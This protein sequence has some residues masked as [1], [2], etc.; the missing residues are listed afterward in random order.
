MTHSLQALAFCHAHSVYH[1]DVKPENIVWEWDEENHRPH[2]YLT[3][4]NGSYMNELDYLGV[5]MFGTEPY[6]SPQ[7]V[8]LRRTELLWVEDMWAAGLSFAE[9]ARTRSSL[10]RTNIV[11]SY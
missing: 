5:F 4:F 10:E 11:V 8:H 6:K 9:M 3:D 2:I 7:R 1:G